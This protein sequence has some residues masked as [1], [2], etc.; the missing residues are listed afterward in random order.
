MTLFEPYWTYLEDQK[1]FHVAIARKSIVR[2]MWQRI[3][4]RI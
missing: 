1:V 3:L 4:G 2:A